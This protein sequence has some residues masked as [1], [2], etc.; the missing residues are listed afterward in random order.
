MSA[1]FFLPV[2]SI[3]HDECIC[4][5]PSL[6]IYRQTMEKKHED[7]DISID[8]MRKKRTKETGR[9]QAMM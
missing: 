6:S 3:V 9:Q 1:S 8:R 7:A 4:N 2:R 5:L